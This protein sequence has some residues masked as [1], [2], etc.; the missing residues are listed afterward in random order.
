MTHAETRKAQFEVREKEKIRKKE[1]KRSNKRKKEEMAEET[2]NHRHKFGMLK[3]GYNCQ[4][5]ALLQQTTTSKTP[6]GSLT[7]LE[8]ACPGTPGATHRV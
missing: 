7:S 8:L 5:Q 6:S 4:W 2:A 3:D 1:E